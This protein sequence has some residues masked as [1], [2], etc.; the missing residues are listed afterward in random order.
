MAEKKTRAAKVRQ[1]PKRSLTPEKLFEALK[2]GELEPVHY[3]YAS[4]TPARGPGRGAAS[5]FNDYLLD[6]ALERIRRIAVDGNV[7]DL[8]YNL[9]VAPDAAMAEVIRIAETFPMMRRNRLVIV[10][11]AHAFR[12]ADWQAAAAYF[13]NPAP[14]T[15]L[16]LV[17][18]HFPTR[19]KGGEA[20]RQL[21]LEY[22]SCTRFEPFTRPR[23]VAPFLKDEA[24]RRKLRLD[25]QAE[26]GI[27]DA[28]GCDM[29]QI[30]QALDRLEHFVSDEGVVRLADVKQC[31]ANTRI[32]EIWD[33]LDALAER[34]LGPALDRLARL[35][36]N[37]KPEDEILLMGQLIRLYEGLAGMRMKLDTG[38]SPAQVAKNWPGHP[39]V[40]EK[41]LRNVQALGMPYLTRTLRGLHDCDRAIRSSRVPGRVHFE[42]FVMQVCGAGR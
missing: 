36:E 21:V 1:R 6:R 25:P 19:N 27:L 7:R 17:G 32:E 34:R 3:F 23:D 16:V 28:V 9:F 31:V 11:D 13:A 40:V 14:S 38:Q 2:N 29:N 33:L 30:L 4:A 12:A 37:A 15:C 26:R 35:L 8:N 42:R 22:A 24:R 18:E 20:G 5:P 10:K 39:F 41:R